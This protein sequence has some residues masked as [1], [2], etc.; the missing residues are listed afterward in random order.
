MSKL[1]VGCGYL[2]KRLATYWS[3]EGH[4]VW[5]TTR[6]KERAVEFHKA[7][8]RPLV[9]DVTDKELPPLPTTETAV[10]CVGYDRSANNTIESVYVDGLRR[11]VNTLPTGTSRF[12]YVSSTGVYG[13]TSDEWVDEDTPC[14][15]QRGGGK[16]C[17]AAESYLQSHPIFGKKAIILRL[18]G[19]YGPGRVPHMDNL[20][21]ERA[22]PVASDSFLNLIHVDDIVQ[23]IAATANKESASPKLLCVSDGAPVQRGQ[24]YRFLADLLKA[25]APTFVPPPP[26]SSQAQRARGS[27]RVSNQRLVDDLNY[28][29][30]YPTYRDGL[31]AIVGR[32]YELE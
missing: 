24:F 17:F 29:F 7:G 22:L 25:S 23:V 26:G 19:I 30:L 11:I 18:A 4:E 6:S 12:I 16:A 14:N 3:R 31:S 8:L 5:V 28:E 9:L 13:Q 20:R 1:I 21:G 27:K 10:F 2:G 15:P 32:E